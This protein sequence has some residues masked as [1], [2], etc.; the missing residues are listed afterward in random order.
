MNPILSNLRNIT[1]TYAIWLTIG[2]LLAALLVLTNISAWANALLFSIPAIMVFGSLSAS[3]YYVA[4]S[5]PMRKRSFFV[6]SG[7]FGGTALIYGIVWAVLCFAWNKLCLL[8]DEDWVGI[9]LSQHLASLLLI[10]G[11][12]LY[13]LSILVYD[14]LLALDNIRQAERREAASEVLAR[15]AE[16]QVLRTQINP[17]FLFNS[18]NSISALTAIDA[19]AARNMT[20]E[21]A[22]FFRQTLALSE[23][24]KITLSEEIT[25][26]NHFLVIEK[27]R[28]GKK[29]QVH[30]EIDPTSDNCLLPPMLLQPLL[31][32]AIKHGIRDLIDGGT[33]IVSSKVRD[34][35][36]FIAIDNPV[37]TQPSQTQ[38]TGTGLK[39]L[40][41]RLRTLYGD[42]SRVEW[43]ITEQT[44][45][46]EIALPLERL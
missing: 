30:M 42:K 20:I 25:L 4:R 24:Q 27:I 34:P 29:L 8:F 12:L 19:A 11:T 45:H 22:Q 15:D 28:F 3:A 35:W 21:L 26:C 1:L 32:N 7:V 39:N 23:K 17:H 6:V 5:L 14:V 2:C 38:G 41:A 31:E 33:I 18:L 36:L 43:R 10:C 44:F 37:D 46:I 40:Q 9:A 13:L 16:L